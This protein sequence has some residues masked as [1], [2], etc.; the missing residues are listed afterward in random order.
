[1]SDVFFA[2]SVGWVASA[3]E[4]L[5]S[6]IPVPLHDLSRVVIIL[7]AVLL[8]WISVVLFKT[9]KAKTEDHK[10]SVA[11]N[12]EKLSTEKTQNM[13]TM[14]AMIQQV[15]DYSHEDAE[16]TARKVDELKFM[17]ESFSDKLDFR[18]TNLEHRVYR[19]EEK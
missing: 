15:R 10:S 18:L 6:A 3:E 19:L 11:L 12:A 9:L 8:F 5:L 14:L 16:K 13:A 1:M 7:I 2:S 4:A 17:L